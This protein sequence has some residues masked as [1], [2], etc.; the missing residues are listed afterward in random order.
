MIA[1]VITNT[2]GCKHEKKHLGMHGTR[3]MFVISPH[4]SGSSVTRF[5]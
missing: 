4:T 2:G 1:A 3:G 5:N